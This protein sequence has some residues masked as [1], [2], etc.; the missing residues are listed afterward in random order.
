MSEI[1]NL[2]SA[3]ETLYDAAVD[4]GRWID[5]L[6]KTGEFVEGTSA[7]LFWQDAAT[8]HAAIFHAW[9]CD[10]HYERLY[11]EKYGSLNPYFPA[12]AFVEVGKPVA[13]ADLIPHEEFRQTRF[14]NE[15]VKPQGL[16]DVI[17]VNLERTATATAFFVIR[18]SEENGVID[19]GARRRF[20]LIAPHVR[21]AASV[22]KVVQKGQTAEWMLKEA[23]ERV[24]AAVVF[25][26]AGGNIVSANTAA[27]DMLKAGTILVARHGVV[28]IVNSAADRLLREALAVTAQGGL[29]LGGKG[30]DV[31][32]TDPNGCDYVANVLPITS[33]AR[34]IA[35]AGTALAALFV[36]RI[37]HASQSPL[38][39]AARR[40]HLTPSELRVLA[41]VLEA[42]RISDIAD[43]L[44]ISKATVKTHLNHLMA[45]TG[46]RRQTDLIQLV[47]GKV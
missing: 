6:Q 2:S 1:E 15:W 45:K 36:R 3:I 19:D 8:R 31:P 9:N 16:I 30:I 25:V 20:E 39:A 43:R 34:R 38:E 14:Y 35:D 21:R 46:A 41:S 44:G 7:T 11:C 40:Y 26:A 28:R 47:V 13:G 17:G 32:I 37:T 33:A 23:I 4:P 29:T 12:L 27:E 5:A 42:G 18:R 10:P 22:G 24:D